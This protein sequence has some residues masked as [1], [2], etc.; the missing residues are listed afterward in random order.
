M[1]VEAQPLR[2]DCEHAW[3]LTADKRTVETWRNEVGI[4]ARTLG[5][6]RD[7]VHVARLGATE[8][9][10]NVCKHVEVPSCELVVERD[11]DVLCVRLFD[12]STKVPYVKTPAL[13]SDSGRGLW[14]L[15]EMTKAMGYTLTPGGKWVWFHCVVTT[16]GEQ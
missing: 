13:L 8:L 16:C 5:A 7:A 3:Q 11:G 2:T 6:D 12:H 14:L 1:E 4:A 10:S 15:R 9:L